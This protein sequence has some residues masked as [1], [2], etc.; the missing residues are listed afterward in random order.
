MKGL[1]GI[2]I[3]H[4]RDQLDDIEKTL[5][6]IQSQQ[7]LSVGDRVVLTTDISSYMQTADGVYAMH[8]IDYTKPLKHY[9]LIE[10]YT[11]NKPEPRDMMG[12]TYEEAYRD[13][14]PED[15]KFMTKKAFNKKIAL[16]V[17]CCIIDI[18]T[19]TKIFTHTKRLI[20]TSHLNDRD[21]KHS[22]NK[23]ELINLM[24]QY[25]NLCELK[26]KYISKIIDLDMGTYN[27]L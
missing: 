4:M 15:I 5:A 10:L 24:T 25:Y 19:N 7:T 9:M 13:I 18:S 1:N 2:T 17:N 20:R 6:S 11:N 23:Q 26:I 22:Y 14:A 12:Y 8:T 16:D 3:A 27:K 21:I